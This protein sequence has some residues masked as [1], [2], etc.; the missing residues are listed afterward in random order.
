[1]RRRPPP[2]DL[3]TFL[4]LSSHNGAQVETPAPTISIGA[5]V[6]V[7]SFFVTGS[8]S[9]TVEL[10]LPVKIQKSP[11]QKANAKL[12]A[13]VPAASVCVEMTLAVAGSISTR[14]EPVACGQNPKSCPAPV[15]ES[16][17]FGKCGLN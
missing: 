4:F 1:C 9:V 11:P 3:L 8:Y 17:Q 2:S 16:S 12:V 7:D 15:P 14:S 13:F 6:T 5:V 10:P